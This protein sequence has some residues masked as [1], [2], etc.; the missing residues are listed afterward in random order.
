MQEQLKFDF[1]DDGT[2][3]AYCDMCCNLSPVAIRH[4]KDQAV[5]FCAKC[6]NDL[7]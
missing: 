1:K 2:I 5:F 6:Y 4:V 7:K 3:L